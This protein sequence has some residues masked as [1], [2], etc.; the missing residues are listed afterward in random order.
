[1]GTY[2]TNYQLYM[3]TIGEQG[4]GELVNGN[5]TTI[6][7]TMGDLN[8]RLTA[9]ENEVDGNLS[10]TSVTTSGT[11]TSTGLI[12]ANGGIKGVLNGKIE[13]SCITRTT[14]SNG[15]IQYA[16]CAQQSKTVQSGGYNGSASTGTLT[17]N[18]YTKTSISFPYQI[19]PGIIIPSA[20]NFKDTV[21]TNPKRTLTVSLTNT[22]AIS[23]S[24]SPTVLI[25]ING[26]RQSENLSGNRNKGTFTV[27]FDIYPGD[28]YY[29][30][31]LGGG[32][33]SM[34]YIVAT[35]AQLPTY[36]ITVE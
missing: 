14:H 6:D 13:L 24:G 33:Q 2:T 7:I 10:C 25:G 12:A 19:V 34:T 4:W 23:E 17:V 26:I 28:T 5:F 16:T 29:A 35:V 30:T 1:M 21:P 22:T 31:L 11:I 3:P 20:N 15:D 8:T 32:G 9:V 18:N 27:R 36:Y